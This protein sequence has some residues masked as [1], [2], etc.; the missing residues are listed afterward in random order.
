METHLRNKGKWNGKCY[1]MITKRREKKKK[2]GGGINYL[3]G[4]E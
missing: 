2:R 4:K 1:K 3:N